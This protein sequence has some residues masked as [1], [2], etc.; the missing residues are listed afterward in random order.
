MYYIQA[1]LVAEKSQKCIIIMTKIL[2]NFTI[3]IYT[4]QL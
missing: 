4:E 1:Q 2:L 3:M